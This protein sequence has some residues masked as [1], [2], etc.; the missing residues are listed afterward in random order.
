MPEAGTNARPF[1]LSQ[2]VVARLRGVFARETDVRRVLIYGSRAKG[3]D[4]PGSDIDLALEDEG[5]SH[6]DLLRIE[7]AIDDLNLP[8]KIDLCLYRQIENPDLLDH[9]RRVGVVFFERHPPSEQAA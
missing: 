2:E 9:I 6:A 7:T 4:R 5:L 3:N 8:Y 1:G